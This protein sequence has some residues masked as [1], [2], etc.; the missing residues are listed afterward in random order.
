MLNIPSSYHF[1]YECLRVLWVY[2]D[3]WVYGCVDVWTSE[4]SR[5]R[6]FIVSAIPNIMDNRTWSYS[7]PEPLDFSVQR[8]GGEVGIG[9]RTR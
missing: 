3:E 7:T 1:M 5:T 9:T 6:S 2:D 8:R 4:I